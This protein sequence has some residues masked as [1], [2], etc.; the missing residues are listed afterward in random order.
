MSL[1]K[2][3]AIAVMSMS[4]YAAFAGDMG[5]A[6]VKGDVTVPCAETAFNLGGQ[7]LY[8]RPFYS[9]DSFSTINIGSKSGTRIY[10]KTDLDS[11]WGFRL[12]AS[13]HFNNGNDLNVNWIDWRYNTSPVLSPPPGR[14]FIE[15]VPLEQLPTLTTNYAIGAGF[16]AVN[17]EFGQLVNL[18]DH[19]KTRLH[20]DVQYAHITSQIVAN[21][22]V[23][24]AP[25]GYENYNSDTTITSRYRYNGVGPRVG[26]DLSYDFL[27]GLNIYGNLAG[28]L[29]IGN[30]EYYNNTPYVETIDYSSRPVN[31]SYRALAPELDAKLG[32][33]YTYNTVHGAF[34]LD[35]GYMILNYFNPLHDNDL[36]LNIGA[37][38]RNN[39]DFGL[40]GL[41]FGAKWVGSI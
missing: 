8:L 15:G 32:G 33:A 37:E 31:S 13:Y 39:S 19:Q 27:N 9:N 1:L 40:N 7:A 28:A 23:T 29:L 25:A 11:K 24:G 36:D 26:A 22:V 4:S 2:K 6:C 20:A 34:T 21:T 18:G 35:V 5:P 30:T 12:E 38:Y 14:A 16:D 3:T 41:Y 17:V 10:Q